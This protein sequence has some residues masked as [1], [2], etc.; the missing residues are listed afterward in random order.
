M[1]FISIWKNSVPFLLLPYL[2]AEIDSLIGL[3]GELSNYQKLLDVLK[4]R[5][6]VFLFFLPYYQLW[7]Q[8]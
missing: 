2:C 8:I 3:F 6:N 5:K 1:C 4:V 7:A